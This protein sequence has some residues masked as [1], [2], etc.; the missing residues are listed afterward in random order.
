MLGKKSKRPKNK[1]K[2]IKLLTSEK[3]E[4]FK[5]ILYK[6]DKA[7]EL[8]MEYEAEKS[9]KKKWEKIKNIIDLVEIN[10]KYNSEFL[11]L[12]QV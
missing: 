8:Y 10:P 12:N 1:A 7:E 2:E 6:L 5:S 4:N 3:I 9:K 11:K